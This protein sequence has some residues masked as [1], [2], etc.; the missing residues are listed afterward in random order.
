MN[1]SLRSISGGLSP[2][3]AWERER[4]SMVEE[5]IVGR[6]VGDD[7]VVRAMLAV[8]RHEFVPPSLRDSA[9]SDGPLPVGFG[10]T[11]SQP[12]IVAVMTELLGAGENSRVLEIGTG[13]GYQT[14]VLAEVCK[15]VFSVEI[16]PE[17]AARAGETLKR[18]G[19]GNVMLKVGDGFEGWPEKAPF[20]G[21]ILTA[22]PEEVPWN[23][24]EQ[25]RD[26]GRMVL[27]VGPLWKQELVVVE[28]EGDD[29]RKKTVF[30]VRFVPMVR[31]K[32]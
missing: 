12:Y 28:R 19:Y 7:R 30:P 23:L 26:G 21:I 1:A 14:A 2:L 11:I 31:G 10:Q 32:K 5:Q 3:D 25:L 20:D 16:V 17:L 27:P 29:V 24:V 6:G 15:E 18:L 13:T 22:A 9:Y 4:R 8:P